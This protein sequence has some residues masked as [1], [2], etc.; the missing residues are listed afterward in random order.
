[1]KVEIN[2]T[3]L[4]NVTRI[5]V[6][7]TRDLNEQGRIQGNLR[8]FIVTITRAIES[9]E[10]AIPDPYLELLTLGQKSEV[11]VELTA[12]NTNKVTHAFEFSDVFIDGLPL[13]A[14]NNG[15]CEEVI[16]MYCGK[17]SMKVPTGGNDFELDE[18]LYQD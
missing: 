8:P 17:A 12:Q 14:V 18:P 1:M 16:H 9:K 4:P 5:E 10:D 2:E 7:L 3:P 13:I 11:E 6:C 15:D